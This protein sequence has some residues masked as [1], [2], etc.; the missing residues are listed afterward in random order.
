MAMELLTGIPIFAGA[1]EHGQLE[2]IINVI[3]LPPPELVEKS[4]AEKLDRYFKYVRR[5][6]YS[7]VSYKNDSKKK[8]IDLIKEKIP[9]CESD[10]SASDVFNFLDWIERMLSW[11]PEDRMTPSEALSHPFL[12]PMINA[13]A[14]TDYTVNS[15]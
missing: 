9:I 7:F 1:S 6:Q 15:N 13:A 10:S 14:N 12:K 2:K 8:L 5:G 3:G 11:N 4:S